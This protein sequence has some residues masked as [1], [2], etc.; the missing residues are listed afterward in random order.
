M[1]ASPAAAVEKRRRRWELRASQFLLDWFYN[2][3]DRLTK[4][5]KHKQTVKTSRLGDGVDHSGDH[6]VNCQSTV[7]S[8]G[9]ACNEAPLDEVKLCLKH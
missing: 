2:V 5:M 3:D 9:V 7:E 1:A 4:T 8:I 6:F